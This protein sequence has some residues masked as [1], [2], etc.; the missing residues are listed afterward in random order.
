[1]Y[2]E[3]AVS[4][5]LGLIAFIF[6]YLAINRQQD[7]GIKMVYLFMCFITL[8]GLTYCIS[9]QA[10]IDNQTTIQNTTYVIMLLVILLTIGLFG[11][12]TMLI[13]LNFYDEVILKK[14]KDDDEGPL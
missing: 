1:M 8:M 2:S 10:R 4:V 12:Y 6:A 14:K 5:G 7:D 11:Y 3:T 9:E 13:G